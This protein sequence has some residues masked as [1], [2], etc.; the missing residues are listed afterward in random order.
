VFEVD[1]LS[2]SQNKNLEIE[3]ANI[4]KL[5]NHPNILNCLHAAKADNQVFLAL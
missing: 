4:S 5:E 2:E 1:E 3:V